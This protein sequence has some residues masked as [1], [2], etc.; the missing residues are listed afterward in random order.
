MPNGED[1]DLDPEE[2]R[3]EMHSAV[4]RI[5]KKFADRTEP[6]SEPDLL[7]ESEKTETER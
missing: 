5:R 1:I 4:E 6:E 7:S 3:R 2:V